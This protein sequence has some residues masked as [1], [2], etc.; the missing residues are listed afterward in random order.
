MSASPI[1]LLDGGTGHL[2]K[3]QRNLRID[4]LPYDQQFLAGAVANAEQ[5]AA[6][7]CAHGSYARAGA[8]VLTANSF[9][10]APRA[11]RLLPA[12]LRARLWR[13]LVL[14]RGR[15]EEDAR[16][17]ESDLA[18]AAALAGEAAAAARRA[19]NAA[20]AADNHHR[21]R[22]AGSLPPLGEC[23]Y[24]RPGSTPPPPRAEAARQYLALARAMRQAA[25]G[26]DL[27]LLAETLPTS[28]EAL[29]ALD[30]AAALSREEEV[31][32]AG[33][34]PCEVWVSFT[35]RDE[36]EGASP[37]RLRGGE[38]LEPA[39]RRVLAHPAA[40]AAPGR[41]RRLLGAVLV[42][43]CAPAAA[44]AALPVLR[45]CCGGASGAAL[46]YGAYA[47]GFSGTTSEW[48]LQD[49][50][51]DVLGLERATRWAE[52]YHRGR[53]EDFAAED[54]AEAERGGGAADARARP[55]TPEAYSRHAAAWL[56]MGATVVG[57]CCGVG[58]RH[59][60]RLRR[61]IDDRR[62]RRE[63]G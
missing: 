5:P 9:A 1:L 32:E 55:I 29:A 17:A 11:L 59:I 36:G 21:P 49:A 61:E 57:G 24:A 23:C 7:E 28:D 40:A 22:V 41:P 10:A 42:N 44:T 52:T 62:A 4:G 30:A 58:P 26:A 12:D 37:P 2:L 20:A 19:A 18:L 56:R 60:S 50:G 47:N 3:Q 31:Q 48:L 34:P 14:E 45:A 16:D 46:R 63:E 6:V 13:R 25:G 43:C 53:A 54:E 35:V 15:A 8:D 51:V 33:R 39:V 27:L 38:A